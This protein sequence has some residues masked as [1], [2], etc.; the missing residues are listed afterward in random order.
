MCLITPK[1]V[2]TLYLFKMGS[3]FLFIPFLHA[4]PGLKIQR[5]GKRRLHGEGRREGEREGIVCKNEKTH[6]QCGKVLVVAVRG[7]R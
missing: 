1:A 7:G 6:N 3:F 2:A 4:D 5:V